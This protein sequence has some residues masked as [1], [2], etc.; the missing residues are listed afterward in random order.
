MV[1]E[2]LYSPVAGGIS[3]G[4]LTGGQTSLFAYA[5][6]IEYSQEEGGI[7]RQTEIKAGMET[8]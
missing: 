5:L 6:D 7:E 4:N 8:G 1:A 2:I 3:S